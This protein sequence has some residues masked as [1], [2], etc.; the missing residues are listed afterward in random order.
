MSELGLRDRKKKEMRQHISDV[1]TR[2]F[3]EKGFDNV[4][5][6]DVAEECGVSEKTIFNYFIN[7]EALVLDQEEPMTE[8]LRE[9]LGPGASEPPAEAMGKLAEETVE[10]MIGHGLGSGHME[11]MVGRFMAM[12]ET[13]PALAAARDGATKRLFDAAAE[14]LSERYG[15]DREDAEIRLTAIALVGF[16][17][18]ARTRAVRYAGEGKNASEIRKLTRKDLAAAAKLLHSGLDG[19]FM[20]GAKSRK[21]SPRK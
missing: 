9:A 21:G 6:S 12:V 17:D 15:R 16:W 18:I 8:R 5:V 7:K 2:M 1:A 13:T 3:M 11:E 20:G 10:N 19:S 4:R 14:S